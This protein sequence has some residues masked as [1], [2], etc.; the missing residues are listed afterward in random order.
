M[1]NILI[2][3]TGSVATIKLPTLV[4]SFLQVKEPKINVRV[5]VT[6]HSRHFFKDSDI[7]VGVT[8]YN[9][10]DEW[11]AWGGRGDP[12]LHI[13]LAKW[14][15]LFLIAPLDANTLGKISSGLCDNLLTCT[16]RAW[17]VSKP[18]IFCPAMNTK[19]YLH[20]LTSIQINN[21]KS[22]GY[23]EIPVI[24]K[25]LMCGDTGAGAMAEVPTIVEFVKNV[26][27]K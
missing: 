11:A 2:G 21:L 7:D 8:I 22:W 1:V 27:N 6:E 15:D 13:E 23:L 14:A 4:E 5:V 18:L 16:A 9:D 24:E 25:T 20:P 12:V 17:D 19:M 3:V 10:K 26:L